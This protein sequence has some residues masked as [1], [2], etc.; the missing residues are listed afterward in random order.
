MCVSIS[1]NGVEPLERKK[2][3]TSPGSIFI[4]ACAALSIPLI[5]II[6][7][8]P[9]PRLILGSFSISRSAFSPPA[10][11][12]S[13]FV[14]RPTPLTP[15]LNLFSRAGAMTA[16]FPS[17]MAVFVVASL[18]LTA[19]FDGVARFVIGFWGAG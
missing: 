1:S 12:M 7:S 15:F 19:G 6:S 16:I 14:P 9:V 18:S 10:I 3:L 17:L 13:L 4:S 5:A 8:I 2:A 11:P